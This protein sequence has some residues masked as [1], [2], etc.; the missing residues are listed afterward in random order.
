MWPFKGV[1]K[2]LDEDWSGQQAE[3][4]KLTGIIVENVMQNIRGGRGLGRFSCRDLRKHVL[5]HRNTYW[6]GRVTIQL[7]VGKKDIRY[8]NIASA[9]VCELNIKLSG[10]SSTR[11]SMMF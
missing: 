2:S 5:A 7:V 6:D 11:V 1:P 9:A 8:Q 3:N 10:H 4:A